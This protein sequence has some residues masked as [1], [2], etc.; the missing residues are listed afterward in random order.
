MSR[1][2][3]RRLLLPL[4]VPI[5]L[6]STFLQGDGCRSQLLL[7]GCRAFGDLVRVSR[8]SF[9]P[10][11]SDHLPA[12]FV[13]VRMKAVLDDELVLVFVLGGIDRPRGSGLRPGPELVECLEPGVCVVILGD[14]ADGDG[15]RVLVRV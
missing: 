10:T 1:R 12:L 9:R 11:V 14:I 13:G 5:A 3:C 2:A 6:R 15:I 7:S 4:T 8:P